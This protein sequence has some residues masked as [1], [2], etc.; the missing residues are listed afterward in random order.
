[1]AVTGHRIQG[2]HGV[3]RIQGGHGVGR[4][5]GGH[6]VGRIKGGRGI[7]RILTGQGAGRIQGGQGA[8]H[9]QTGQAGGRIRGEQGVRLASSGKIGSLSA[10]WMQFKRSR[11]RNTSTRNAGIVGGRYRLGARGAC[12]YSDKHMRLEPL[13]THAKNARKSKCVQSIRPAFVYQR[14]V[15]N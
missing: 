3:G 8:G 4:I 2:A 6:G 9:L 5:Q 14:V 7:G 10:V 12:V 15:G 1:M 13:K 11:P